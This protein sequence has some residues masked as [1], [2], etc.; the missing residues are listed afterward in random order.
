M[1]Q[2]EF[3]STPIIRNLQRNELRKATWTA[4]YVCTYLLRSNQ[5][6]LQIPHF[7]F[8]IFLLRYGSE[9]RKVQKSLIFDTENGTE[10]VN[11]PG[12]PKTLPGVAKPWTLHI[13]LLLPLRTVRMWN[14]NVR[15]CNGKPAGKTAHTSS[16]ENLMGTEGANDTAAMIYIQ[17][18]GMISSIGLLFFFC[19]KLKHSF[20]T[21]SADF[22]TVVP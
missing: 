7:I 3:A 10:S 15:H 13:N 19:W 16:S 1:E 17:F 14:N 12:D 11:Q 22:Q 8:D 5:L 20:G 6:T 2:T 18:K 21:H 9:A 4:A